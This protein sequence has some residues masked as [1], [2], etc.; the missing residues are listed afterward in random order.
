VHPRKYEHLLD[1]ELEEWVDEMKEQPDVAEV[2]GDPES[3]QPEL[4]QSEVNI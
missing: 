1:A 2:F 3:S 4:V